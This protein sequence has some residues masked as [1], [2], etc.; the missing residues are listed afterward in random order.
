VA[1]LN[2]KGLEVEGTVRR[3]LM[4]LRRQVPGIEE[5]LRL[6]NS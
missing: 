3:E 1:S 4:D 2:E 6:W 5:R